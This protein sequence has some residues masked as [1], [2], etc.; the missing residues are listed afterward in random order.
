MLRVSER[1]LHACAKMWVYRKYKGA[2]EDV[3]LCEGHSQV[4]CHDNAQ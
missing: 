1:E 2:G 4:H 3:W